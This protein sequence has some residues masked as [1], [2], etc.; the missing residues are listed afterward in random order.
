MDFAPR[1]RSNAKK[2]I[3]CFHMSRL[4]RVLLDSDDTAKENRSIRCNTIGI[5]RY[6]RIQHLYMFVI[7]TNNMYVAAIKTCAFYIQNDLGGS[8]LT[9]IN[10]LLLILTNMNIF[11][12]SSSFVLLKGVFQDF[13]DFYY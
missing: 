4:S 12:S 5:L 7:S 13:W 3:N 6:K 8:G 2:I 1:F 10:K 11:P 9:K